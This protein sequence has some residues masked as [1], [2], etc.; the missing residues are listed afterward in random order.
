[1]VDRSDLPKINALYAQRRQIERVLQ[2]FDEGGV[3]ISLTVGKQSEGEPKFWQFT[4]QANTE[5][6]NYPQIMIDN[7]KQ[8][9][10]QESDQIN[11]ELEGMGL[12]GVEALPRQAANTKGAK[13]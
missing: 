1:M 6:M 11:S 12:T 9:L 3:I 10:L 5:R 4:A 2:L 7:I 8:Y 13:K